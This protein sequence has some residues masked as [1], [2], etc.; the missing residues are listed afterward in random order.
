MGVFNKL[1]MKNEK[2]YYI[3]PLTDCNN[4]PTYCGVAFPMVFKKLAI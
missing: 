1:A 3:Y 4:K 2:Y